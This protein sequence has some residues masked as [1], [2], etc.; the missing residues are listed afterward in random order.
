[1]KQLTQKERKQPTKEDLELQQNR[2]EILKMS[3]KAP[4][5]HLPE[6]P[7]D[8]LYAWEYELEMYKK[9]K[10]KERFYTF[11][12]WC[13][14]ISLILVLILNYKALLLLVGITF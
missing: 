11:G 9:Q 6:N 5:I 10:R 7:G 2:L 4:M 3:G 8:N 1:M 13:G 12:A 14:V